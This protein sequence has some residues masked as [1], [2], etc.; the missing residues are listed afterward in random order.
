MHI[1]CKGSGKDAQRQ[2]WRFHLC[3]KRV[4]KENVHFCFGLVTFLFGV[5]RS[6]CNCNC[7]GP[8]LLMPRVPKNLDLLLK[9]NPGQHSQTCEASKNVAAVPIMSSCFS[10]KNHGSMVRAPLMLMSWIMVRELLMFLCHESM[11]L[12]IMTWGGCSGK[13]TTLSTVPTS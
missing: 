11:S 2:K 8:W 13:M 12:P 5:L 6:I 4:L 10:L 9:N 7:A 3:T 1:I